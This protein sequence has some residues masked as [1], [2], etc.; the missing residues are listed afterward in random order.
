MKRGMKTQIFQRAE[1]KQ[2]SQE[3]SSSTAITGKYFTISSTSA[4]FAFDVQSAKH[5]FQPK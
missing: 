2:L 1:G 5:V 4:S 3:G